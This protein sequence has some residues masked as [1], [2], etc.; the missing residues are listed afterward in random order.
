VGTVL[1]YDLNEESYLAGHAE[2]VDRQLIPASTFKVFSSLVALETGV[3][4]N[5]ETV[6]KWD[7]RTRSRPEI[8]K[9]L[10]LQEAFRVSAVPHYQ[11]LVRRIGSERMQE[12]IDAVGY[13]NG[14]I[15]GGIDQFW[16]AGGLRI[17][18][19]EQIDFLVRLS[20]GTLPFSAKTMEMVKGMMVSEQTTEY[21][22]RS[23]TGW[24]VPTEDSHVGWWV[25]W[26]ERAS[27]VHVFATALETR[28]P[29]ETFGSTRQS[30]TREVLAQLGVLPSSE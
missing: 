7:G 15:S 21:T 3:I 8:N 1:V 28:T 10:D 11:E 18:P 19:R 17:S 30:V 14:D 12:F 13:G 2:R 6:I 29:G 9:D 27:G 26:V 20:Q 24:G 16:L 23:K 25:G 22:I 4:A 5:P